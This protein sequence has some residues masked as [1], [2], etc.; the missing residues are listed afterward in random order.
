MKKCKTCK[1][2]HYQGFKMGKCS[3]ILSS[4]LYENGYVRFQLW[5]LMYKL[6]KYCG[7]GADPPFDTVILIDENDL[8][9]VE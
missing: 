7:L 8:Y 3:G 1:H 6:G 9:D 4:A 2:W 5:D